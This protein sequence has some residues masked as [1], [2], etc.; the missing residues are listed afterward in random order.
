[1]S[2]QV[3]I[4]LLNEMKLGKPL[5]GRQPK[6]WVIRPAFEFGIRKRIERQDR[7]PRI[8]VELWTARFD[9]GAGQ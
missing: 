5:W 3:V 6:P 2:K 4:P 1:V 8:Q 9:G 7:W